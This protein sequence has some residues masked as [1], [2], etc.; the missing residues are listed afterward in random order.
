MLKIRYNDPE[1]SLLSIVDITPYLKNTGWVFIKRDPYF[2]YEGKND[3]DGN[4]I[5]IVISR[6][7][8]LEDIHHRIAETINLLSVLENRS[9]IEIIRSI[10]QMNKKILGAIVVDLGERAEPL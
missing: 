4:P 2:V 5:Q 8:D 6:G 7:K 3:D 9:P 1:I 10:K